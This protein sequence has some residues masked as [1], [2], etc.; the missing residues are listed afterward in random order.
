[1]CRPDT[2]GARNDI[3]GIV[4]LLARRLTFATTTAPL[5]IALRQATLGIP[6]N[7]TTSWGTGEIA[8]AG[9]GYR[10]AIAPSTFPRSNS[11]LHHYRNYQITNHF[12]GITIT[13][14]LPS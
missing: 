7:P 8:T 5:V 2:R 6:G 9:I 13:R 3:K 1:M 11:G 10:V 4:S 14:A 12:R